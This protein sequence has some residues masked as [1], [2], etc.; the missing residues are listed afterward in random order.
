MP[1]S[2]YIVIAM[3]RYSGL[4]HACACTGKLAEAEVA[5]GDERAHATRLGEGPG[6][7]RWLSLAALGIEA[8]RDGSRDVAE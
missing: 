1:I 2:R 5:V 7:S 8:G 4:A 3:V 6:A